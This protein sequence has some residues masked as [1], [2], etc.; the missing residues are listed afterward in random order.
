MLAFNNIDN[1]SKYTR[2]LHRVRRQLYLKYTILMFGICYPEKFHTLML[3]H[4]T[5]AVMGQNGTTPFYITLIISYIETHILLYYWV[6]TVIQDKH[7]TDI[8]GYWQ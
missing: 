1:T 6:H 5:H 3:T 4:F 2:A 7:N 8:N